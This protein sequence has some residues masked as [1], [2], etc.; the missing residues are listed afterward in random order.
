MPNC[1]SL[2]SQLCNCSTGQNA[3]SGMLSAASNQINSR[4]NIVSNMNAFM[5]K[6]TFCTLITHPNGK[7]RWKL[8]NQLHA[9]T[10]I[11]RDI[12]ESLAKWYGKVK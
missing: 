5:A 8:I 3:F 1:L 2:N 12:L 10:H 4:I 6:P 9:E 7:D 11:K